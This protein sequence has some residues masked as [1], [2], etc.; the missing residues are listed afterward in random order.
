MNNNDANHFGSIKIVEFVGVR[1][2]F[3]GK[4][5]EWQGYIQKNAVQGDF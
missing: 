1:Q 4:E 3:Y 5:V 2:D